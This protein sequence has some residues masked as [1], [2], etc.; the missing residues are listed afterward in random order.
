MCYIFSCPAAGSSGNILYPAGYPGYIAVKA[1]LCNVFRSGI[2]IRNTLIPL[3]I[4]ITS[5]YRKQLP[6]PP[7][8]QNKKTQ[9]DHFSSKQKLRLPAPCIVRSAKKDYLLNR[10]IFIKVSS[11]GQFR[12]LFWYIEAQ[13]GKILTPGYCRIFR[14]ALCERLFVQPHSKHWATTYAH[15]GWL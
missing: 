13:R 4:F 12:I 8:L 1:S 3:N 9:E 15:S 10:Y 14:R 11:G 7:A 5:H 2:K 6:S